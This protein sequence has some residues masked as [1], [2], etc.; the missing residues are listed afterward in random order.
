ML[1]FT[2]LGSVSTASPPAKPASEAPPPFEQVLSEARAAHQAIFLDVYTAWC[3]PCA[4]LAKEVFPRPEVQRALQGYRFVSYDAEKGVGIDVAERFDVHVYPTLLVLSS[5]GEVIKRLEGPS[6]EEIPA[7]LNDLRSV[8]SSPTPLVA[9]ADQEPKNARVQLLAA[10]QLEAGSAEDRALALKLLKRALAADRGNAEGI[11]AR[12]ALKLAK[13]EAQERDA[14]THG[15]LLLGLARRFPG[16]A[17]AVTALSGIAA[18]PAGLRPA[19]K[20]VAAAIRRS[21]T[22][23]ERKKDVGGLNQLIYVAIDLGAPRAAIEAGKALARL[24]PR[25]GGNLDSL[26]EAYFQAGDRARAIEV[27]KQAIALSSSPT[28]KHNLERFQSGKP[29][30]PDA[31]RHT[32]PLAAAPVPSPFEAA[33]ARA[34]EERRVFATRLTDRVHRACPTL[35]TVEYV[36]LKIDAG[37]ITQAVLLDPE[38]SAE[39][40][41]CAEKAALAA[42]PLPPRWKTLTTAVKLEVRLPHVMPAQMK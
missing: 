2:L 7:A 30:A 36:R 37:K 33:V 17:E 38:L 3:Q 10:E 27:E 31:P 34:E 35:P 16:S 18:F 42:E 26:A 1:L 8:A 25:D 5:A 12:A 9:L 13:A 14:R 6:P 15:A 23:L 19:S 40:R 28:L 32:D 29:S 24:T 20:S 39:E 21:A 22:A 4:Y 41:A 11:A